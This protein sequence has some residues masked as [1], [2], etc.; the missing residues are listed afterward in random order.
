ML[1]TLTLLVLVTSNEVAAQTVRADRFTFNTGPCVLRSGSGTPE[2]V[3]TGNV[4]DTFWRTD[5]G[6][7]Y[8]K[9]SGTG[10][11]GWTT[12]G[13]TGSGTTNTLPLWTG[14]TT[15]GD[16]F[17]RQSSNDIIT[18]PSG[19]DILPATGY[20]INLGSLTT[21]Y[22]SLHAAELWVETLVAQNTMATIGGRVIVAPTTL[23]T[24]DLASGAT[25]MQ[26]KHNDLANGDRVYL[27]SNGSVE[28]LAV[29]SSASG[30][31][32]AYIYSI[33][34]N[35]DG[36]GANNWVAGDAVLNTGT[37]GNGF[38]DLYSV[39]GV[40]A[41]TEI[42]PTIVGNVRN[43]STY[44]DWSPHWAI[45]N[46]NGLYG[47]SSTTHGSVF[48][49][50]NSHRVMIDD[51][52]GI[53]MFDGSNVERVTITPAGNATF[54]GKLTVGTG[55]NM[56][57][58]SECRVSTDEWTLTTD[59]GLTPA[60]SFNVTSNRLGDQS[61]TCGVTMTGTPANGTSTNSFSTQILPTTPNTKYEASVYLR[62]FRSTYGRIAIH[63][64]DSSQSTVSFSTGTQCTSGAT[65][66]AA[67]LTNYCRSGVVATA[68]ATAH[69]A[70]ILVQLGH[71]G[72]GVD[73]ALYYVMAYLGEATS[74]QTGLSEWGPA[75]ITE[76]VGGMIK[77]DAI[78][79]RTIAA[80]TITAS[81]IAANAITTSEL[82]ADS[83]T[84]AK[85]AANTIVA[86]DIAAGTIT[87][88]EIAANTIVAGDIAAGTITGTEIAASTIT[89][90]NLSVSTLSAISSN[91]GTLTAGSI[92]GG[93]IDG[94][95]INAGSGD[96]VVLNSSG[97]TLTAGTGTNNRIK[98]SDGNAMWG[99]TGGIFV[100]SSFSIEDVLVVGGE[101][102][103]AIDL[104]VPD[105]GVADQIQFT[106][107]PTSTGTD[108]IW[109]TSCGCLKK[110]SSSSRYKENIKP[111]HTTTA[112]RLLDLT[113]ISFDYRGDGVKGVLG[114]SAEEVFQ[115]APEAVN[116][117]KDGRPDSLR[118]DAINAY[119]LQIIRELRAEIEQLK[120]QR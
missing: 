75:G 12:T 117:D 106:N 2:G 62:M 110:V 14:T 73:P 90:S 96:E 114:F 29:T 28:F 120:A 7:I 119:L 84:S 23:L 118:Q 68:P 15:L 82:N 112:Q 57:R 41:G 54:N 97:I 71:N 47:Y 104:S 43:S 70:R 109:E 66:D 116:L 102:S 8:T 3:V 6:I 32:G 83:V 46:L 49:V 21:K 111:W 113:P 105:L 85:I 26:V 64:L 22:L 27:E 56:I 100:S 4:C 51:V 1:R 50:P 39:R 30:S 25:S 76:I 77:T 37:T 72:S 55:R 69:Y 17:I 80:D 115:V 91:M 95:T 11:T 108:V 34:R 93:T 10:N 67:L 103:S 13:L 33:T 42:G 48:G 19:N 87:T 65:G 53:R 74:E 59:S 79:A 5:T 89:A 61:S 81:E 20:D 99:T 60:L 18:D 98:W 24:A 16:S 101:G 40:K 94:A 92:T 31:A 9:T 78:D 44:N 45:G 86:G 63:W 52:N 35:L 88:T 107:M 36:S 58:N 38:I